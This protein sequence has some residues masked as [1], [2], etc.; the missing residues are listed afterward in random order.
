[1]IFELN[2]RYMLIYDDKARR[3]MKKIGTIVFK[4][5]T[6]IKLDSGEILNTNNII[7]AEE[8]KEDG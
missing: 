2:K 7:R 5:N 6:L 8:L 4:E 3:P 1:M